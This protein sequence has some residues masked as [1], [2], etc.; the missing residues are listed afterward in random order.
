MNIL[1]ILSCFHHFNYIKHSEPCKSF[2]ILR[3]Y[4][5][6]SFDN[7]SICFHS[8]IEENTI[9]QLIKSPHLVHEN[10]IFVGGLAVLTI[11]GYY[12]VAMVS[13]YINFFT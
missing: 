13:L 11:F 10:G 3:A 8:R 1:I 5:L 7:S 6:K 2:I 9:H 4:S 12:S